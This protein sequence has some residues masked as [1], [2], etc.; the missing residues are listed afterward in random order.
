[1]SSFGSNF[2]R[3]FHV[4]FAKEEIE[5]GNVVYNYQVKG[6][7][8]EEMPGLSVFHRQ[9]KGEVFHTYSTYARG[10]EPIMGIYNWLDLAPKGRGEEGLKPPIAWVRHHDRYESNYFAEAAA[11]ETKSAAAAH[12]CCPAHSR[13][14]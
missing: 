2:N 10:L 11:K 9:E 4:S 7:R 5:N 13:P 6:W 12:D 14:V 1:M 8:N 3:D